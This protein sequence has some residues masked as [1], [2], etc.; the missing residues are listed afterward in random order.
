MTQL[1]IVAYDID[2]NVVHENT[3]GRADDPAN[4]DFTNTIQVLKAHPDVTKV[5]LTVT[6]PKKVSRGG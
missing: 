3:Y 2:E 5:T 6:W 4:F 1:Q